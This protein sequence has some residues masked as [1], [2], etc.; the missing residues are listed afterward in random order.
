MRSNDSITWWIQRHV[1][2]QVSKKDIKVLYILFRSFSVN[3]IDWNWLHWCKYSASIILASNNRQ[4]AMWIVL[5]CCN[6]RHMSSWWQ[7][8]CI[9]WIVFFFFSIVTE[10]EWTGQSN[11]SKQEE[12]KTGDQKVYVWFSLLNSKCSYTCYDASAKENFRENS[13][14]PDWL[15]AIPTDTITHLSFLLFYIL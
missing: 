10:T 3:W 11:C 2:G 5:W 9:D 4:I 1:I 12:T 14:S 7:S 13:K 15:V 6:V 8:D